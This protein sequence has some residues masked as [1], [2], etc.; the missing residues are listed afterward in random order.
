MSAREAPVRLDDG[1]RGKTRDGIEGVDVLSEAALQKSM[2]R[3]KLDEVVGGGGEVLAREEL[4][5]ELG[6]GEA[7]GGSAFASTRPDGEWRRTSKKGS[8]RCLK[9]GRSKTASA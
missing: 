5:C 9:K 3:K 6:K 4:L 2:G 1:R 7:E 8:G